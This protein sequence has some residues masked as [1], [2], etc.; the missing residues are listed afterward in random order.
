M[1]I[2]T[3]TARRTNAKRHICKKSADINELCKLAA[4]ATKYRAEIYSAKWELVEVVHE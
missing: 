4:N 1:Y 3:I 2:L